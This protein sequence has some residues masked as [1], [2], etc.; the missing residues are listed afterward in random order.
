MSFK[1]IV[2]LFKYDYSEQPFMGEAMRLAKAEEL[3][4]EIETRI[5]SLSARLE[6]TRHKA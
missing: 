5:E 3:M 1:S 4:S 2:E 6:K